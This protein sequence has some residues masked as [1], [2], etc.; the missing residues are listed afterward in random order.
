[1][2]SIPYS[3]T[4]W[5]G[6][7]CLLIVIF[8]EKLFPSNVDISPVDVFLLNFLFETKISKLEDEVES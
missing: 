4:C 3:Y 7:N 1:M 6:K 2:Q 5:A 8:K